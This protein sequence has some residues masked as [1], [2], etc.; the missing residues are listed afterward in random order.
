MRLLNHDGVKEYDYD[1]DT[2]MDT[3]DRNSYKPWIGVGIGSP[4]Y[5]QISPAKQGD[6]YDVTVKNLYFRGTVALCLNHVL[7]DV[8]FSNIHTF[9]QNTVFLEC[10]K[11]GTEMKNIRM[12]HIYYGSEQPDYPTGGRVRREDYTGRLINLPNCRGDVTIRHMEADPVR[13]GV[14]L[15]GGVAVR[16]ED[17]RPVETV[18]DYVYDDLSSVTVDGKKV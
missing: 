13:D 12:D 16:L 3:S 10:F 17:Y 4:Y 5:A 8:T 7:Q 14:R 6:T 18:N 1:I 15:S 9:D 2:L 11:D